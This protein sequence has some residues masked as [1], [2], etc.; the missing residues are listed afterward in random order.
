MK[1]ASFLWKDDPWYGLVEGDSLRPVEEA[2]KTRFPSLR[3]VL[4]AGSVAALAEHCRNQPALGIDTVTFLP[5]VP[6]PERTTCVGINYPKRYPLDANVG[7]PEHII[8]FAKLPGTI[9]GHGASLEIPA[10]EAA[11][12]FDYEGEIAVIIGR[13]GRHIPADRAHEHIAGYTAF[14]DG[15]V[16]GWQK[17][18]VHAGKNFAGSGACGPW[19]VTADEIGAPEAMT[20]TT[21]L[22]GQIVQHAPATEM[23]FSITKVIAYVSHLAPIA[24]G[25]VIAM[26]S[27][28]GSGGSRVPPRFLMNG[29]M[30]EIEVSGVGTLA[31]RIGTGNAGTA[32]DKYAYSGP[33]G[34]SF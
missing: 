11:A 24:P 32:T 28:E 18:S 25:D 12:T 21:R 9:L 5:P 23:F 30:L 7:R 19:M 20:V 4:A 29:D 33:S 13:P 1:I 31:N 26:G 3:S 2:F 27:P 22:N 34:C 10:G 16:R 6:D 17:H 8:L 14:N 15:S